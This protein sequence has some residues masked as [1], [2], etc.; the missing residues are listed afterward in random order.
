MMHYSAG[1]FPDYLNNI[2]LFIFFLLYDFA[3]Q[4]AP[5]C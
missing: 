1:R 4:L 5:D 2:Y 3:P